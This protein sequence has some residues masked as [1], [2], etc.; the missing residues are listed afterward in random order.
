MGQSTAVVIRDGSNRTLLPTQ[1][2]LRA[3]G[4]LSLV[5]G[6]LASGA[7]S[8]AVAT[9][10]WLFTTE[11]LDLEA[12]SAAAAA[13][14]GTDNLTLSLRPLESDSPVAKLHSG[15]WRKCIY[16]DK[17]DFDEKDVPQHPVCTNIPYFS[18]NERQDGADTTNSISRAIRKSSPVIVGSLLIM[19]TALSLSILGNSK[20]D[21]RTLVAAILY[22]S[23]A[24]S[25][26]VGVI[27]Y[28]SAVNDEV[29]HRKK[30]LTTSETDSFKYSYGW[31]FFFAGS[32]FMCAM[33]A[34]VNN[35]SLYLRRGQ[36]DVDVEPTSG[37]RCGG[38]GARSAPAAGNGG[39]RQ[40]IRL[41]CQKDSADAE[42]EDDGTLSEYSRHLHHVN[43]TTPV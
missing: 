30:S 8:L 40:C 16:Y 10:F 14:G 42:D 1:C 43:I 4:H 34:A 7:L 33:V 41:D 2:G 37:R 36:S 21:V 23:S 17:S 35:I 12:L 22:I 24:L 3:L 38:G 31:A 6:L 9:D 5:F 11:K 29:S 20:R 32:S 13:S 15:L 18:D 27:F 25:L 39:S 28:I 19:V 26:A